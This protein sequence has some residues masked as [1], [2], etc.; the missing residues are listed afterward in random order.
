MRRS[1][2]Y[3]VPYGACTVIGS[4]MKHSQETEVQSLD[5]LE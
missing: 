2:G 1:V 5:N 3:I 4:Q